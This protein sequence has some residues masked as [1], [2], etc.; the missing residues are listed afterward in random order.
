MILIII[1]EDIINDEV[2]EVEDPFSP[3]LK[4]VVVGL[5]SD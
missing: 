4:E 2:E 3:A 5:F 1:Y